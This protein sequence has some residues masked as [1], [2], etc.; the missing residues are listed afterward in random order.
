MQL[1][2]VAL[3]ASRSSPNLRFRLEV[4]DTSRVCIT[5]TLTHLWIRTSGE[6]LAIQV[7]SWTTSTITATFKLAQKEARMK[8]KLQ[9]MSGMFIL[10]AVL[11][12]APH[13]VQ[14]DAVTE[15]NLIAV[16]TINA[17]TPPRAAPVSFMDMA[18]VHL[19]VFDAVNAIDPQ[20]EKY[21]VDIPGASG[22]PEAAVAKAAH[23]VLVHLFPAQAASLLTQYQL[24]LANRGIAP[25][26]P[27]VNVGA[28]A[29]AGIIALRAND[30]RFPAN[31]PPYL[32]GTELGQWRPTDSLIGNPPS[33]LP[34]SPMLVPWVANVVPFALKSGDQYR[35]S[36]P[37]KLRSKEYAKAYN[38]AKTIG[39][40]FNSSRTAEETDFALFF[41]LNYGAVWNRVAR[42]LATAHVSNLIA[43]A[44][45]FA[46]MNVSMADAGITAW[47]TKI[48]FNFWR[49]ITAIRFGD[50]DG[51]PDT[52]LDPTWQPL[53]NTPNYPD[54]TSGAN[55]ATASATRA[56][57]L[58]FGTNEMDFT[59]RTTNAA[60]VQQS[61]SY[62]RFTDAQ[63]DVV[64]ARIYQGIHFRFADEDGRKQG[65]H[66]AQWVFGHILRPLD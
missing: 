65:R 4:S 8:L 20:F 47:D 18:M 51:N 6:V 33:P 12:S 58:F 15:W 43:S 26:D 63:E 25:N 37:P 32:G 66:V 42:D 1:Q 14:A 31:P 44:R 38:E 57:S 62:T 41:A 2:A 64:V 24:F 7:M 16:N 40:R 22:S 11:F 61:R 9:I 21:H 52:E 27:G 10:A 30:G 50:Q 3:A 54:H 36:P 48:A 59:V 13:Q 23:D 29:A 55:N 60:A 17:S 53:I 19:A 49:P 5:E 46:L 35:A 28:T 39:A 56:L 45:L 34:F